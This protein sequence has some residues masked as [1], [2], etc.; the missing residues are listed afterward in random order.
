MMAGRQKN[1][2]P[3][4]KPFMTARTGRAGQAGQKKKDPLQ[5]PG[6]MVGRWMRL[7]PLTFC[8]S[9]R[10]ARLAYRRKFAV[11]RGVDVGR[12]QEVEGERQ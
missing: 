7:A 6:L 10:E 4:Q 11:A 3:L 2:D 9:R 12:A 1:T 5:R 8:S